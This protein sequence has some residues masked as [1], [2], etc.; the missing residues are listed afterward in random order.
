MR[1]ERKHL[2]YLI[3]TVL[4][5]LVLAVI[6]YGVKSQNKVTHDIVGTYRGS[7]SGQP[8]YYIFEPTGRYCIYRSEAPTSTI[9]DEGTYEDQGNGIF[10]LESDMDYEHAIVCC[11]DI[12]YDFDMLK[13]DVCFASKTTKEIVTVNMP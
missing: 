11:N 7:F 3:G 9:F 13:K 4:L 6:F 12:I 8:A 2:K 1:L 10:A 5:V